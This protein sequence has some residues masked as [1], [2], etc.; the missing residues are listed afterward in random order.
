MFIQS[1][2]NITNVNKPA[3]THAAFSPAVQYKTFRRGFPALIRS[4]HR[5]PACSYLLRC[6]LCYFITKSLSTRKIIR[7]YV[8]YP[9]N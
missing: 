4:V 6:N 7:C 3:L 1:S 8:I 9:D 5:L 2:K